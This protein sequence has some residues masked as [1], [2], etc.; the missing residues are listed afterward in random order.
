[1]DTEIASQWWR[2]CLTLL[3]GRIY[4]KKRTKG[5]K[6]KMR[7]RGLTGWPRRFFYRKSVEQPAG[8]G[9]ATCVAKE[10]STGKDIVEFSKEADQ[11]SGTARLGSQRENPSFAY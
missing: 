6:E 9:C 1:M 11:E 3:I 7:N 8:L 10:R 4:T 2:S 5:R